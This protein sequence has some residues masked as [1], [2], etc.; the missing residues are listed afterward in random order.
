MSFESSQSSTTRVHDA[1]A[2]VTS[3]IAVRSGAPL[4]GAAL[5]LADA[6]HD[7]LHDWVRTIDAS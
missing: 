6:V 1:V 5:A 2:S 4:D 3:A 7:S